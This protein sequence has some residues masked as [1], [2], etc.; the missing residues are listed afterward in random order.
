MMTHNMY[1]LSQIW[2]KTH[3]KQVQK[4]KA[5]DAALE[6]LV[7]RLCTAARSVCGASVAQGSP[8][9][10][11]KCKRLETDGTRKTPATDT[12]ANYIAIAG[13]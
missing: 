4:R 5:I 6:W 9:V 8:L 12:P 11:I 2:A 3:M 7:V 1:L 13:V 10:R